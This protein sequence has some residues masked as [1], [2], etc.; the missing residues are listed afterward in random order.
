MLLIQQH[1][2]QQRREWAA[3]GRPF[4][5]FQHHT[6][7]HNARTKVGA[8]PPDDASIVHALAQ[9]VK[10]DIVVNDHTVVALLCVS[11]GCQHRIPR[12]ATGAKSVAVLDAVPY[13][14]T[15]RSM[16]LLVRAFAPMLAATM[17]SADFSL[18]VSTSLL[19]A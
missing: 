10:Q 5:T 1:I 14:S 7:I 11:L 15:R 17:A 2:G 16:R 13:S 4:R 6:A 9:A 12:P 19:Q 8:D 18:R 3:L